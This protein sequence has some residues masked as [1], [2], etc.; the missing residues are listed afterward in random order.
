M[1]PKAKQEGGNNRRLG[2]LLT[3]VAMGAV[4]AGM[5]ASA[6]AAQPSPQSEA[7]AKAAPPSKAAADRPT[8]D[9]GAIDGDP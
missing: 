1:M 9:Q 3:W 2:A 7:A 5:T 8:A 6:A 4:V